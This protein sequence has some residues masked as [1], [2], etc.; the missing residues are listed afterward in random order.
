MVDLRD[1]IL[2]REL[3]RAEKFLKENPVYRNPAAWNVFLMSVVILLVLLLRLHTFGIDC[4][5]KM[6]CE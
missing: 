3:E 5:F 4:L 6:V 1:P 2:Q